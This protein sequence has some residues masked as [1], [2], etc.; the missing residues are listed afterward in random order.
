MDI[1]LSTS[2]DFSH[3]TPQSY[4]NNGGKTWVE[5]GTPV[6]VWIYADRNVYGDEYGV[7]YSCTPG[8]TTAC[9]ADKPMWIPVEKLK[10]R[11][12]SYLQRVE[13]NS[14]G[15]FRDTILYT[16]ED[17]RANT[18][19]IPSESGEIG[20][21][22][23]PVTWDW[24]IPWSDTKCPPDPCVER[25]GGGKPIDNNGAWVF[26]GCTYFQVLP[27]VP[28]GGS[29][30]LIP[31]GLSLEPEQTEIATNQ[32][33]NIIARVAYHGYPDPGRK[34][35]LTWDGGY[36]QPT[37]GLT[38]SSGIF[39]ATFSSPEP[40]TYSIRATTQRIAENINDSEL[41]Q[42]KVYTPKSLDARNLQNGK[43][44]AT[45]LVISNISEA[46]QGSESPTE[47]SRPPTLFDWF[48]SIPGSIM[49]FVH[50]FGSQE[51]GSTFPV[52][53][54]DI[55]IAPI[56]ET[57][58]EIMQVVVLPDSNVQAA[59][60]VQVNDNIGPEIAIQDTEVP[61]V[62]VHMI[63][64][65]DVTPTGTLP[66]LVVLSIPTTGIVYKPDIVSPVNIPCPTG[67]YK[68][69]GLCVDL[70]N[71]VSNCGACNSTCTK[72]ATCENGQC[73]AR[74]VT[75]QPTR[76]GDIGKATF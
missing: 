63:D 19:F 69:G 64:G 15:S 49:S 5:V 29:Y 57:P 55:T 31:F 26:G 75:T 2:N 37:S 12:Y 74:M 67:Y 34:V 70:M 11:L 41:I 44:S 45:A 48:A 61:V 43:G 42:I 50:V 33:I 20:I 51:S 47:S 25:Y 40:G 27:H 38:N 22:A 76:L 71:D 73:V 53:I 54:A 35:D 10:V 36:L 62:Q 16:D 8:S 60:I 17:G 68:C 23:E 18:T 59:D 52:A 3:I 56:I 7:S 4:M 14:G 58:N 46:S 6:T 30:E 9:C 72:G 66:Q 65:R 28:G 24:T 1:H 21:F 13:D 32:T 39:M